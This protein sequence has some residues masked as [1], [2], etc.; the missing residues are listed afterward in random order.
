M[1]ITVRE[2]AE[3]S[4]PYCIHGPQKDVKYISELLESC[5]FWPY[6]ILTTVFCKQVFLL[7]CHEHV[8]G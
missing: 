2:V 4:Q 5:K 3:F 1:D 6:E 8:S 7:L